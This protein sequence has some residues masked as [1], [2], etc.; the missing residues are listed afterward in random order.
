MSETYKCIECGKQVTGIPML[1]VQVEDDSASPLCVCSWRCL[2]SYS[3][4][5]GEEASDE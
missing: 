1:K 4:S 3:R 2:A 5:Q